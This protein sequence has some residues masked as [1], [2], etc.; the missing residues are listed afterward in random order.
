MTRTHSY[1]MAPEAATVH[2]P[3]TV[4]RS[5]DTQVFPLSPV[6]ERLYVAQKFRAT[7]AASYNVRSSILLEGPLQVRPLHA[8]LTAVVARHDV[9]R[10]TFSDSGAQLRQKVSR[11]A[12]V[13]FSVVDLPVADAERAARNAAAAFCLEVFEASA[14]PLRVQCIRLSPNQHVLTICLPHLAADLWSLGL[15]L[16]EWKA[17]Y[18]AGLTGGDPQLPLARAQYG[19]YALCERNR[20]TAAEMA[21]QAEYWKRKLAGVPWTL[22]NHARITKRIEAP[23]KQFAVQT[24]A[25]RQNA[26]DHSNP[27]NTVF[28]SN[29]NG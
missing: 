6:Q 11:E 9:L 7:D 20:L 28:W 29:R 17:L 12:A 1:S 2:S 22:S 16:E 18:A 10:S 25:E 24:S 21:R 4:G 8:A 19:E 26:S 15:I 13:T 3:A 14:P 23:L 5:A 27:V